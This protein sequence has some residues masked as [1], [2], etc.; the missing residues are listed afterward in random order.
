[1]LSSVRQWFDNAWVFW[2]FKNS[3]THWHYSD[4]LLIAPVFETKLVIKMLPLFYPIF[5][6]ESGH[7]TLRWQ[8]V[9]AVLLN[10][11]TMISLFFWSVFADCLC[12]CNMPFSLKDIE[13]RSSAYTSVTKMF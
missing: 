5:S 7:T 12:K 13:L 6:I 1:M 9:E 11:T 2:E 4:S 8:T 10:V 3:S